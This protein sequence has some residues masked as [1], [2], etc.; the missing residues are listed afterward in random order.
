MSNGDKYRLSAE[1]KLAV[2]SELEGGNRPEA[3][4]FL[5][6][7]RHAATPVGGHATLECAASGNPRPDITW[8]KDG[9]TLDL[10]FVFLFDLV[11]FLGLNNGTVA[12]V[13]QGPGQPVPA[14]RFGQSAHRRRDGGRRRR[15]PV[16][17][18]ELGGLGRRHGHAGRAVAAALRP[19]AAEPDGPR[20]GRRR[21]AL[22]RHRPAAAGH[23]VDQERRAHHR[24]RVLSGIRTPSNRWSSRSLTVALCGT[25]RQRPQ[26]EDPRPGGVRP[27][28]LPVS[29]LQFGRQHPGR[30][31]AHHSAV[32]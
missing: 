7:P 3:P 12:V 20:E 32:R 2:L 4:T 25:D 6:A 19:A 16:P 31:P 1:A 27:R 9:T 26:F 21:A 5:A 11:L 18:R 30:R 8:L 13:E 14:R 22:P 10:E 17:R 15:L 23:P 29:G 24:E 28:R